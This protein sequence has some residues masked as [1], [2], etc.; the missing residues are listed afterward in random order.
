[1]ILNRMKLLVKHIGM[2]LIALSLMSGLAYPAVQNNMVT[3]RAAAASKNKT[4]EKQVASIVK[5]QVADTDSK[6]T[7]LKKLF[8]YMQKKYD[9]SSVFKSDYFMKWTKKNA[10]KGWEKDFALEMFKD[11]KGS[12]FHYAAAYAYLAKK[13]ANYK[14]RIAVGKTTGFSGKEQDHAWVEIRIKNQWHIFDPNMDKVTAK[15]S[16]KYFMKKRSSKSMKKDYN[17]FKNVKYITVVL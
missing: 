12:C 10:Y 7:K 2:L 8:T 6:K 14:V 15:S 13:A 9:C 17:Q 5:T 3:V 4:V 16:G 11:K 1:M